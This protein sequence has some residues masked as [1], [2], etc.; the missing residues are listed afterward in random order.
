MRHFGTALAVMS[1]AVLAVG[2]ASS[3]QTAT[4]PPR[5]TSLSIVVDDGGQSSWTLQCDP[6]DGTHPNP[7]EACEFLAEAT[8]DGDDP[9]QPVDPETICAAVF[10]GAQTATVTGTWNGKQVDTK[11]KR[12]NS[13]ETARW[14]AALPLLAFTGATSGP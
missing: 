3:D 9:F 13:C 4:S 6:P 2:C 8:V 14:D 12:T 7:S 10:S 11:F 5:G 1:V